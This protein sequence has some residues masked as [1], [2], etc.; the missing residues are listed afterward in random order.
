MYRQCGEDSKLKNRTYPCPIVM[1]VRPTGGQLGR[2]P[3]VDR[4]MSAPGPPL[5]EWMT[6]PIVGAY[7]LPSAVGMPS[8]FDVL[9]LAVSDPSAAVI[10]V[11]VD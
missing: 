1:T 9:V 10:D 6:C 11:R 5:P 7:H 3:I 8:W 2:P 4:T